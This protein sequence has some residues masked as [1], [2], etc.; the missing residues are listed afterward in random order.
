MSNLQSR[1]FWFHSGR[2]P[3]LRPGVD[4]ILPANA[5]GGSNWG[6]SHHDSDRQG[7]WES[8]RGDHTFAADTE[9]EAEEWQ[10]LLSGRPTTYVVAAPENAEREVEDNYHRSNYGP[11]KHLKVRGPMD[12]IDRIDIPRPSPDSEGQV[13]QGT[14]GGLDW[15][16]YGLPKHNPTMGVDVDPNHVRLA[17]EWIAMERERKEYSAERKPAHDRVFL[18]RQWETAGQQRLFEDQED[19]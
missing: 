11:G 10:P 4:Q 5:V 14:I 17:P 7:H 15:G 2:E 12:I 9:E 1:Q 18:E 16:D 6:Y 8:N 3:G 13:V 19:R